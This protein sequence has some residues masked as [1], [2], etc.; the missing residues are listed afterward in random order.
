MIANIRDALMAAAGDAGE[1]AR[2]QAWLIARGASEALAKLAAARSER[3][4]I[5]KLTEDP[6]RLCRVPKWGFVHADRFAREGLGIATTDPRRIRGAVLHVLAELTVKEDG[7]HSWTRWDEVLEVARHLL[8]LEAATVEPALQELDAWREGERA[9]PAWIGRAED[10]I[11]RFFRV[12]PVA[13]AVEQI[14]GLTDEQRQAV[15]TAEAYHACAWAGYA[16][17]GKTYTIKALATRARERK[18]RVVLCALAGKAARRL[19]EVTGFPAKTIHRT[20]G[21]DGNTFTVEMLEED[22]VVVDEASMVDANLLSQVVRRLKPGAR[23]VLVGDPNQLPSIG[24]G[25]VLRDLVRHRPC[26]VVEL[27]TIHRQ[28]GVVCT[29]ALEVLQGRFP[30]ETVSDGVSDWVVCDDL[31]ADREDGG[32]LLEAA[33]ALYE[34]WIRK[35]PEGV[36]RGRYVLLAPMKGGPV[37]VEALNQVIRARVQG[38][39]ASGRPFTLEAA[40]ALESRFST[41]DRV[42]WIQNDYELDLMNG[43]TGTVQAV[44]ERRKKT[45]VDVAWDDGRRIEVLAKDPRLQL[46]YALTIHKSQGSE[47]R[48]VAVIVSRAHDIPMLDRSLL[49]TAVTRGKQ[50]VTVLGD[51]ATM[52]RAARRKNAADRRTIC[53]LRW[54]SAA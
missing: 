54:G 50:R 31:P 49:Y 7:C 35:D 38:L 13:Q 11:G 6:Y 37:G 28:A 42:L 27:K 25:A 39:G 16:G 9:A 48:E 36:A 20:L 53:G 5:E 44:E 47:Y 8:D 1:T 34:N 14:S 23:L 43:S 52:A 22:L 2:L 4:S 21:F 51:A 40:V 45:Y 15:L 19:E 33:I 12:E 3:L 24:A 10:M 32:I 46:A 18:Q 29:N 30:S 26:P 17:T 41:R